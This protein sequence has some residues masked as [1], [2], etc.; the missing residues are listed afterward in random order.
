MTLAMGSDGEPASSGENATTGMPCVV[1]VSGT[2]GTPEYAAAFRSWADRW[3]TAAKKAGAEV[4][5]V[6]DEADESAADQSSDHDRLK[7]A[8]LDKISVGHEPLWLVLIGHGSFDGHEAKFN[9]KGAD[10][11]AKELATWLAPASRP[12]VV[13]DCSSASGPFLNQLSGAGRV[14][15]TATRRGDET[16]YSR[17][18]LYLSQAIGDEQS[19]LDKDGQVS[20]LEAFLQAG[21]RV[22]EYYKNRSQLATEHALIDDNGDRLG[23]PADWFTGVRATRVARDG[24]ASDGIRAH[25]IH[26]IRSDRERSIPRQIREQRDEIE[27]KVE[28]LRSRKSD[29]PEDQYYAVLEP[30]MIELARLYQQIQSGQPSDPDRLLKGSPPANRP[31]SNA[32]EVSSP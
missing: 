26:L 31:H 3:Q 15:V 16:N 8:L 11:S 29:V 23:T 18:G 9:L 30:L 2:P 28:L 5:R 13:I 6:G 32:N 12:L 7:S 21:S 14:V 22:A 10:V 20:L 19:D 1:I 4:I 17:F 25:Q 27:R 24:A